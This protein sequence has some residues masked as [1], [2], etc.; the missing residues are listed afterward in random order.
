MLASSSVYFRNT[1]AGG[2]FNGTAPPPIPLIDY[3][4]LPANV[5]I[6]NGGLTALPIPSTVSSRTRTIVAVA[7]ATPSSQVRRNVVELV[8]ERGQVREGS[9]EGEL[10]KRASLLPFTFSGFMFRE[11]IL[12]LA[13]RLERD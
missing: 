13:R 12:H 1:A 11:P 7:T 2:I 8:R 10:Q 6:P 3:D 5:V 9:E 4:S